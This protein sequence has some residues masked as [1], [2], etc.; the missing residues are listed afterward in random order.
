MPLGRKSVTTMN[1]LPSFW[2]YALGSLFILVT[3]FLPRGILGLIDQMKRKQAP[4]PLGDDIAEGGAK[5]AAR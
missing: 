1:R 2:L 4:T 3:L 5:T